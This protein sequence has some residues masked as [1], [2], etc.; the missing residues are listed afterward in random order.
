MLGSILQSALHSGPELAYA[1]KLL[2]HM[3]NSKHASGPIE[4]SGWIYALV[5]CWIEA[6]VLSIL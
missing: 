5:P 4:V 6:G 2:K 3:L 1:L